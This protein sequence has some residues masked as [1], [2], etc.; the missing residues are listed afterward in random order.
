MHDLPEVHIKVNQHDVYRARCTCGAEHVGS[1][2]AEVSVAP[3]SYG[4]N[5]KARAVYLLV[6][7]HVP[8]QRC[9]QLI[10]DLCS[11]AGV[12]AGRPLGEFWEKVGRRGDV[13]DIGKDHPPAQARLRGVNLAPRRDRAMDTG[14]NQ[15]IFVGRS[16]LRK[17]IDRLTEVPEYGRVSGES[18]VLVVEG[19]RWLRRSPLLE[20]TRS[21][22]HDTTPVA[23]IHPGKIARDEN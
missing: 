19:L 21:S 7:Q 12:G 8:V 3:S 11:G 2:P 22:W 9:V 13:L 16:D 17:L 10:A 14:G 5:L 20:L 1:L 18:L 6:Y 15:M 4:V 23:L